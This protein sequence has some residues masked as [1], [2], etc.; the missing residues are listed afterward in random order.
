MENE[1][2]K[3]KFLDEHLFKIV[4]DS[5]TRVVYLYN[6]LQSDSKNILNFKLTDLLNITKFLT[7]R[8]FLFNIANKQANFCTFSQPIDDLR[9]VFTGHP[10]EFASDEVLHCLVELEKLLENGNPSPRSINAKLMHLVDCKLTPDI[11]LTVEDE[12]K[13]SLFYFQ[14]LAKFILDI[15]IK[16]IHFRSWTG[17]DADG[18][19]HVTAFKMERA[20]NL[21]KAAAVKIYLSYLN[22]CENVPSSTIAAVRDLNLITAQESFQDKGFKKLCD[23]FGTTVAKIDVRQNMHV[24]STVV[25]EIIEYSL[26]YL[27]AKSSVTDDEAKLKRLFKN[28]SYRS[29]MPRYTDIDSFAEHIEETRCDFLKRLIS[30]PQFIRFANHLFVA[31]PSNSLTMLVSEE[32]ERIK[33]IHQHPDFFENYIISNSEG[34]SSVLQLL[35][36][37][38]I[39]GT[40][41]NI[42]PLFETKKALEK[43]ESILQTMLSCEVYQGFTKSKTQKIMLGY[44]DSEK[45]SGISV[46][47]LIN[48]MSEKLVTLGQK[49]DIKVEIFH[50]N[51]LDLGRGGAFIVRK[52]QTFQ[53]N[54]IRYAFS[55]RNSLCTHLAKYVENAEIPEELDVLVEEGSKFFEQ[56]W[57]EK[58]LKPKLLEYLKFASPFRLFVRSNNFSSRPSQRF[59]SDNE[60]HPFRIWF[61][62]SIEDSGNII[63]GLRAIPWM[64]TAE[65]T[66]TNFNLW[67]GF[68][69]GLEA[70]LNKYGESK[71]KELLS[72]SELLTKV[73]Y[74]LE[75]ADFELAKSY[76]DKDYAFFSFLEKEY[77][78]TKKLFTELNFKLP[79]NVSELLQYQNSLV[80]PLK[81]LMAKL[82]KHII[83]DKNTPQKLYK[84][85]NQYSIQELVAN[86]Y[87]GLSEARIPIRELI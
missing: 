71:V 10:T 22:T 77:V 58:N 51:G 61:T 28:L 17:G 6:E 33:A 81:I 38:K 7:I 86:I 55:S 79:E 25:S 16:S 34:Y 19:Y 14:N 73:L 48:K 1:L 11:R 50:G 85:I 12:V 82:N 36:L 60:Q 59:T 63:K 21:H 37:L 9:P 8:M 78:A 69:Q 41:V 47:P 56:I 74:G 26:E 44:S 57:E 35:L 80:Y 30:N 18:N 68:R 70:M 83:C 39:T 49:H 24:H 32:V 29:L 64:A 75:T 53:G 4:Q 72:T 43:S 62:D 3:F 67:L 87:V 13:R 15:P 5:N 54:H 76:S 23:I 20:V 65:L 52:E 40:K 31:N 45:H 42:V 66:F 2:E 84:D 27:D 46:L